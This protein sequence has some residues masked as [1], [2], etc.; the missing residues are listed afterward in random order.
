MSQTETQFWD[1]ERE[2]RCSVPVVL[3]LLL[4][5]RREDLGEEASC[6]SADGTHPV[7]ILLLLQ[8]PAE[9]VR[10]K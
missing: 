2:I 8:Q 6:R 7:N 3:M 1:R 5:R 9:N 10:R 4:H